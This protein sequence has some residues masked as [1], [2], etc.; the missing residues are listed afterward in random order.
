MVTSLLDPPEKALGLPN[1]DGVDMSAPPGF[2]EKSQ[3]PTLSE[4]GTLSMSGRP[5]SHSALLYILNN[6]RTVSR[7]FL[8]NVRKNV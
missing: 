7:N 5:L 6:Y 1:F 4:L 8:E 3:I 2:K